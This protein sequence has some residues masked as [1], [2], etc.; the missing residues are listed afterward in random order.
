MPALASDTNAPLPSFVIIHLKPDADVAAIDQRLQHLVTGGSGSVLFAL[1]D[2][3]YAISR[4]PGKELRVANGGD[5]DALAMFLGGIDGVDGVGLVPADELLRR[6]EVRG[7]VPSVEG[8]QPTPEQQWNLD[9]VRARQAWQRMGGLDAI[10]WGS[11]RI[12]HLDTGYTE[13]PV[14][15]PWQNG[16]S[17]S[18]RPQ[19]GTN[20]FDG[21]PGPRDPLGPKGTP[22]H[23]TRSSSALA[24]R[25]D[26]VFL[27]VAP[28][29]PV[30]PYRVT[31]FIVI[32]TLFWQNRMGEAINHA[33]FNSGCRIL[34]ISL[35][36]PCYA[37]SEMGRAVDQA[38]ERGVIIV[39]AAG[40]YTSE[41]TY[42]GRYSRTI[43]A[44]GITRN[45]QPWNGGSRG[46]SVDVSAPA[47]D[48]WRADA[49]M[50]RNG[51]IHY[52]YGPVGDG[53]TYATVHVSGA[54]ALWMAHHGRNL[55]IYAAHPWQYV[56]AFRTLIRSTARVPN[57]WNDRLFGAGILDIDALLA[58]ALP[59]PNTLVK[60]DRLAELEHF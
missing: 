35:G 6:Y 19:E 60:Q 3:W 40:N 44:G 12:G 58:A 59:A 38:Y 17:P 52:V 36:D 46:I 10:N 16:V 30:V 45:D 28:R 47:A 56:E 22:G 41:V 31:D 4:A 37:P 25:V 15:G 5:N 33:V 2:G 53:T 1:P 32:D 57:G 7:P 11:I 9:A 24:G 39:A 13:H 27:G 29:V 51:G 20:T 49:V 42:P 34:S 48:I 50:D 55:D 26:N 23:G 43:A 54:A 18:L 8:L 21:S 14:F